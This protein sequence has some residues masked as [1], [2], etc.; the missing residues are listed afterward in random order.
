MVEPVS[1]EERSSFVR[2]LKIGFVFLVGLSG[3][4]ITL[5]TDAGAIGFLTATAMGLV[6]GV[7]L[8]WIAFPDRDDLARGSDADSRRRGRR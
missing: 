7:V 2:K 4:L 1:D 3:G 5:Q 6:V 8:V